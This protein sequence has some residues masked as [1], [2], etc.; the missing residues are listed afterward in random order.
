M[1]DLDLATVDRLLTTT[2]AVRRRLDPSRPVPRSVVL[3][4]LR[5]S[6]QAPTASNQQTW[7]WVVVDDAASF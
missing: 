7:R 2:R 6:Q 4:C 3:D 5:L 1:A